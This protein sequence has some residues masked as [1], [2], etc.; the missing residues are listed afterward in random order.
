MCTVKLSFLF[1]DHRE[2]FFQA[3]VH[4]RHFLKY[5]CEQKYTASE[6]KLLLKS[7]KTWRHI[8]N[9]WFLDYEILYTN[10]IPISKKLWSTQA[11]NKESLFKKSKTYTFMKNFLQSAFYF[12]ITRGGKMTPCPNTNP[13]AKYLKYEVLGRPNIK[14]MLPFYKDAYKSSSDKSNIY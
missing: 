9:Q 3:D 12:F 6:S 10:T 5:V 2:F 11:Y 13:R 4:S 7:E 1:K 8:C 14:Q